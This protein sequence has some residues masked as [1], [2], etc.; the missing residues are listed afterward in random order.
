MSS[1]QWN[2]KVLELYSSFEPQRR[3]LGPGITVTILSQR[4]N[5]HYSACWLKSGCFFPSKALGYLL[6]SMTSLFLRVLRHF[7]L[8]LAL[9]G[10]E[11]QDFDGSLRHIFQGIPS[12]PQQNDFHPRS[13]LLKW[14]PCFNILILTEIVQVSNWNQGIVYI[15]DQGLKHKETWVCMCFCKSL[16]VSFPSYPHTHFRT[17]TAAY[18]SFETNK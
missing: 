12:D 15:K 18:C 14:P 7:E 8:S 10:G 4:T 13:K 11:M 6:G 3:Q 9:A 2:Y 1:L 17:F 5:L 16:C